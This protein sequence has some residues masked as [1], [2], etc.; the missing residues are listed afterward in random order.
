MP[1]F[2]I[3]YNRITGDRLVTEY[4]GADGHRAALLRRLELEKSR[5][6]AEWEIISLNSDSLDTVRKTHSRY[7]TGHAVHKMS[8]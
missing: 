5:P 4:P 2:V 6:S 3:E 8:A 7:F 1:G